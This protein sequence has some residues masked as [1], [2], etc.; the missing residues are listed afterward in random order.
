M[1]SFKDLEIFQLSVQYVK[2]VYHITQSFPDEENYGLTNQL[3]RAVISISANIAE[4]SS[5]RTASDR[6]HF[7]DVTL[8]SLNESHALLLVAKELG[9][10]SQ[11][12]LVDAEEFIEKLRAKLFSYHRSIKSRP[13]NV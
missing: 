13:S 1:G 11:E 5:R 2:S 12:K 7:I 3:R 9:Y 6:Q 4:G 8:G 10:I